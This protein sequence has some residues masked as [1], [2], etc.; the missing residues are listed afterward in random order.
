VQRIGVPGIGALAEKLS[1]VALWVRLAR[2]RR[3]T[4]VVQVLMYPDFVASSTFAGLGKR[5]VM[6][7]AGI[8][9]ATDTLGPTSSPVRRLQRWLRRWMVRRCRN[10]VLTSAL[11]RELGALGIASEIVPVPVD[12]DRFHP[13]TESERRAAR[14]QLDL[15]RDEYVVIVTG[16][17]RRLKA[18]DQLVE[19]FARFQAVGRR[20]RLLVVGGA[21][22]TADSCEDELKAQVRAAGLDDAVT[23]TGRVDGIERFLWAADVFVLPSERE[24][25]SISLLEAMACGLACVAPARPIGAEVL[26]DA[27]VVP[28]GN[29]PEALL[30]ALLFLADDPAA[31]TRLG[32]AAAT[33]ARTAFGLDSVVD[34]YEA[35]YAQL[36]RRTR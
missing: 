4:D 35:V 12:L 30:D 9:D 6:V 11:Q 26:G 29:K 23:F 3:V 20:G 22:G 24:G 16:Q 21:S 5:T 8:G 17:L 15:A 10:I 13:P 31:R 14:A 34:D 25:F 7:W 19:A 2:S 18:V 32:S 33:R 36:A 28:E 27:G 1:V